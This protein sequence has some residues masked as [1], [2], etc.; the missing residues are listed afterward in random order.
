MGIRT[1][2]NPLGTSYRPY[3]PGDVLLDI[4]HEDPDAVRNDVID[5]IKVLVDGCYSLELEAA[6]GAGGGWQ[7]GNVWC[8]GGSGAVIVVHVNLKAGEYEYCCPGATPGSG[9]W[10]SGGAGH[11]AYFRTQGVTDAVNFQVDG[12]WGQ[13]GVRNNPGGVVSVYNGQYVA[14]EIIK[15]NGKAASGWSNQPGANLAGAP[16]VYPVDGFQF[17][18]GAYSMGAGGLQGF[19]RLIYLGKQQK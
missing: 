18:K 4:R 16:S 14:E 1:A 15:S 13:F 2:F 17:G 12:G 6:G 5:V 3:K 10:S 7:D 8:G 11:S 9:K 19:L